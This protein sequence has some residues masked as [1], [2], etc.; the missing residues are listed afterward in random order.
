MRWRRR[1]PQPE[2]SPEAARRLDEAR[3]AREGSEERLEQVR[4]RWPEVTEVA[5][6]L[7]RLRERN[8]FAELV[9]RAMGGGS[10][11]APR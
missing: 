2:P 10:D 5:D 3:A 11:P 7:R 4:E 8:H 6:S 1:R 9:A